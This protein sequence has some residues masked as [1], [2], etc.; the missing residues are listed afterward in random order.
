MERLVQPFS[1]G[2]HI[3]DSRVLNYNGEKV[4]MPRDM[5][6]ELGRYVTRPLLRINDA[7]YWGVPQ[8]KIPHETIAVPD[9]IDVTSNTSVLMAKEKAVDWIT[10]HKEQINN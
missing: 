7:H 5:Y 1:A 8:D 9:D 3:V 6:A 4:A 10:E 2:Y